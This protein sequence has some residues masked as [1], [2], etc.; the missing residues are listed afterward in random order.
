MRFLRL[1]TKAVCFIAF[2]GLCALLLLLG[3]TFSASAASIKR[4]VPAK[5]AVHHQTIAWGP[6]GM[7]GGTSIPVNVPGQGTLGGGGTGGGGWG[8]YGGSMAG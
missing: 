3:T 2:S 4:S 1:S 7:Y 6:G 8:G 5:P